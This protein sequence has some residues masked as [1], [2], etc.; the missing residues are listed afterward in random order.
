MRKLSCGSYIS[1]SHCDFVWIINV[2]IAVNWDAIAAPQ[3]DILQHTI[4]DL[5][6]GRIIC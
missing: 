2:S 3:D 4:C 5:P 1:Y 6:Y